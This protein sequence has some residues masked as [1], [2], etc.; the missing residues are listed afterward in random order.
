MKMN[1]TKHTTRI[2][3]C[4]FLM[5]CLPAAGCSMTLPGFRFAP[6][7]N[8]K[9]SAQAAGDIATVAAITGLPPGS[10]AA[11]QMAAGGRA[12]AAYL[13][14]PSKP[15][16]IDGLFPAG[17]AKAWSTKEKQ[18]DAA[19]LQARIRAK[20]SELTNRGLAFLATSIGDRRDVPAKELTP[21]AQAVALQ[22][23]MTEELA[24]SVNVP[25]DPSITEAEQKR[26]DML[27]S[28]LSAVTE[29]AAQVAS[30]RP[31]SKEVV[32]KA[33]DEIDKGLDTIGGIVDRYPW[34]SGLVAGTP[35]LG[36]L[37]Y[38]RKRAKDAKAAQ[39]EVVAVKA[40]N[41][42][43]ATAAPAAMMADSLR[44]AID[45]L[46]KSTPAAP[47]PPAVPT[48]APTTAVVQDPAKTA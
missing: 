1:A 44:Q 16:P 28:A 19:A 20:G 29:K 18:A 2:L 46:A 40:A 23:H 21:L 22:S 4:L 17:V 36:A 9:A 24:Q 32:E 14:A 26:L 48:S 12:A 11:K 27:A 41:G 8:Q 42:S 37:L 47:T 7:E 30:M 31:T 39:A 6:D 33:A 35:V 34:L 45:A 25:Q 15:I 38:G 5:I 43:A 13:G 3:T 10:E